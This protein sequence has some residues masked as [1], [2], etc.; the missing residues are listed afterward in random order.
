MFS[1]CMEHDVCSHTMMYD[2]RCQDASLKDGKPPKEQCFCAD[3]IEDF[4]KV[5]PRIEQRNNVY[6]NIPGN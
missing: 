4:A 5:A 6:V 2:V 1:S 3:Y